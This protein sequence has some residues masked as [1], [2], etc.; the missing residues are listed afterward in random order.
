M[1]YQPLAA[2]VFTYFVVFS[3]LGSTLVVLPGVGEQYIPTRVRLLFALA[4]TVM[5]APIVA[6]RIPELPEKVSELFFLIGSEV[7][8][9]FAIGMIARFLITALSWGG[10][11]IS[12]LSGFSAAQVFNP[13]L[14]DQGT[15]PAVLLSLGGL[16]LIYATNTHHLMFLA[17]ADS[18]TLFVP[19]VAPIF[20]EFADTFAT[21]LSQSF[22]MAMQ[23]ATPFIVFAI[24]F[25]TGMGLLARLQPQMPVFFVAL[26]LQI[27]IA[28]VIFALV[29]PTLLLWFLDRFE[30]S[31]SFF[32]VAS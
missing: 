8:I 14:A 22:V 17:I 25:Y 6:N 7:F 16:L 28:L 4:L 5:M 19:G 1:F 23:F 21:L 18:Y 31:L 12:F 2:E 10:T 29:I 32:F 27:L 13:M 30:A 9:G 11:V 15:L 26:P 20:G 24:V 3:R